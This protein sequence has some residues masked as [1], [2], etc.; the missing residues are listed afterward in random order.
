V[1]AGALACLAAVSYFAFREFPSREYG[2][3]ATSINGLRLVEAFP[4]LPAFN[5]PIFLTS[6]PDGSDRLFVVEQRGHVYLVDNSPR[7]A[8]TRLALD[9]TDRVQQDHFY[10]G[11]FGMAFHPDARTNRRVFFHYTDARHEGPVISEFKMSEN[12]SSIDPSSE[13]IL[14]SFPQPVGNH[15]GGN[16]E[17][18]PDRFLYVSIGHGGAEGDEFDYAQR[19]DSLL[20]K[21]LR[22]DVDRPQPGLAYGIPADNPF[23]GFRGARPE[24]WAMGFRNVWRFSFDR[25]TGQLWACD[26]GTKNWEEV[27]LVERGGNY[28]WNY[29]EGPEPT[30]VT[31]NGRRF[32]SPPGLTLIEPVIAHPHPDFTA[33]IGGYVYRG[34]KLHF[35]YGKYVYGDFVTGKIMVSEETSSGRNERMI[36]RTHELAHIPDRRVQPWEEA[37][38]LVQNKYIASFGQDRDGEI[39]VITCDGRIAVIH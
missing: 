26:S 16:L 4:R 11:V 19:R 7:A 1:P 2:P 3:P 30:R 6:P 14:I 27:N 12:F 29:R 35:L 17:F 25:V 21:I 9:L 10:T 18:G 8:K 24:A 32:I 13:R 5:M 31:P 38:T 39:Y 36:G 15:D 23:V 37:E 33:I 22:I 34:Q 28:G 20:G